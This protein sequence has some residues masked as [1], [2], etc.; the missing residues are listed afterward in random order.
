MKFFLKQYY[1]YLNAFQNFTNKT[2]LSGFFHD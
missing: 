2:A 1:I